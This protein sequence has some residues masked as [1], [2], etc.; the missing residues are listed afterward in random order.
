MG[1]QRNIITMWI[2]FGPELNLKQRI[3]YAFF[4]LVIISVGLT[5]MGVTVSSIKDGDLLTAAIWAIVGVP[6]LGV[7]FAGLV[8]I[9][10][11]PT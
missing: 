3:G 4:S 7:G 6:M 9:F 8:N 2:S 1:A 10:R 5:L 11:F